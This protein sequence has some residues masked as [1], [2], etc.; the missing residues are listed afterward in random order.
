MS[1]VMYADLLCLFRLFISQCFNMAQNLLLVFRVRNAAYQGILDPGNHIE[2]A[3]GGKSTV[4]IPAGSHLCRQR[5]N[6]VFFVKCTVVGIIDPLCRAAVL[7]G[8]IL[9]G[10][11]LVNGIQLCSRLSFSSPF[12]VL[13]RTSRP[14]ASIIC[15]NSAAV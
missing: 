12:P 8:V 6:R 7:K 5:L 14:A 10:I 2:L 4:I 3:P 1:K 9:D 13:S 11:V 15:V